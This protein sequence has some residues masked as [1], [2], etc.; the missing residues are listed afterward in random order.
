MHT[1]CLSVLQVDPEHATSLVDIGPDPNS[2]AATGFR[3]FWG[4]KAELRRFQA[5]AEQLHLLTAAP[6]RILHAS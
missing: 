4:D 5:S 1:G 3:A 2:P 6:T